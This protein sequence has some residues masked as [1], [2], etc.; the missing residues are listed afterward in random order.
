VPRY[1][2]V[3]FQ[4]LLLGKLLG[5]CR[6]GSLRDQDRNAIDDGIGAGAGL[7]DKTSFNEGK[8]AVAGRAGQTREYRW[9]E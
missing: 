7:A 3:P 2:D 1:L 5:T 9:I 8:A 4:S 6:H